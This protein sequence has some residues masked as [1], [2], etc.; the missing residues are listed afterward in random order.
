M[1]LNPRPV[2]TLSSGTIHKI[3]CGSSHSLALLGD[4]SNITTLSP[5]YYAA[6]E[7]LSNQWGTSS[8]GY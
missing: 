3:A 8:Q 1:K 6:N 5:N 4:A 2:Q 7:I